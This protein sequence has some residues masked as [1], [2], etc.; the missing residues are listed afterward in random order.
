LR[1]DQSQFKEAEQLIREGLQLADQLHLPANAA[2]VASG[3]SAL[4]RI[5]VQNGNYDKAVPV[6]DPIVRHPP[7]GVEGQI[8]LAETL[9]A[10]ALAK[11]NTGHYKEADSLNQQALEL[12]RRLH[13]S[14]H[15]RV[16]I[17]LANLGT[18]K[19]TLGQFTE[20]EKLYREAAGIFE[21]WYGADHPQTAQIKSFVALVVMRSGKD[22]EAEKLLRDVLPTQERA[23]GGA[24]NPAIAFTHNTLGKLAEN[25]GDLATAEVEYA[26]CVE[27]NEQFYGQEQ[28][29]TAVAISNLADVLVRERKYRRAEQT[30]RP[31]V[32]ALTAHPLPGNPT[33][34]VAQLTLGE[35]LL[36]QRR[37]REAE[38]PVLAAYG[39]LVSQ[40]S[41][42]DRLKAARKDLVDVYESLK[43]PE[44]AARFRSELVGMGGKQNHAR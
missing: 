31:A 29:N 37:Y 41:Y 8:V 40:P 12:D 26:R 30:I 22:K 23:S 6:L 44:K 7:E 15:P 38:G 1:G 28:Y 11:Q 17:D 20:A 33:V 2:E 14:S 24:P 19:V 9:T 18:T 39:I 35:S 13:G 4:G 42:A 3:R 34:G 36:G 25:R 27:I 21:A 10:L 5:F 16:A 43:T 32:E